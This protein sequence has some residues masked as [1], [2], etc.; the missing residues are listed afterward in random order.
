M[1]CHTN[2]K[3]GEYHCHR[4]NTLA[5]PERV[6][7]TPKPAAKGAKPAGSSAGW[8]YRNCAA[9]RAVG[10]GPIRKGQPGYGSHLDP[11]ND[12]IVCTL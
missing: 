1:V 11:D 9:A 6:A 4:P 8:S 3:T 10:A 2:R 5:Q 12:G 7:P